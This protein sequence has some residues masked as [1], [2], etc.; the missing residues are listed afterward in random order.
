[1]PTFE[2][3]AVGTETVFDNTRREPAES[4]SET[5]SVPRG[6]GINW[7]KGIRKNLDRV[8]QY[9]LIVEGEVGKLPNLGS[10]KGDQTTID[11]GEVR[12]RLVALMH[13]ILFARYCNLN[14]YVILSKCGKC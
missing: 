6:G 8:A 9:R 4:G 14:I 13:I 7:R 10:V 12:F 11:L 1:M 5:P 3:T 2:Q